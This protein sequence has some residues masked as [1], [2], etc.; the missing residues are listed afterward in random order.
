MCR[1]IPVNIKGD[2]STLDRIARSYIMDFCALVL[3]LVYKLDQISL[4]ACRT[5]SVLRAVPGQFQAVGIIYIHIFD[6]E[7]SV[8]QNLETAAQMVRM[9]MSAYK[10]NCV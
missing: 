7:T 3:R 8:F 9:R 5:A 4:V 1:L 6:L 2:L 10:I